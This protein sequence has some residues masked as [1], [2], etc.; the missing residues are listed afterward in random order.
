MV[1]CSAS[2]HLLRTS[3]NPP[4]SADLRGSELRMQPRG[5]SGRTD[6]GLRS[7]PA[8]PPVTTGI[9]L[10]GG[11]SPAGKSATSA[12]VSALEPVA[13]RAR[14]RLH[15]RDLD[16][17]A[18]GPA[19]GARTGTFQVAV[20]REPCCGATRSPRLDAVEPG[21]Q[22]PEEPVLATQRFRGAFGPVAGRTARPSEEP[23]C[24]GGRAV[25][26]PGP[27]GCL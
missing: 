5:A 15:E 26:P 18:S 9:A 17:S 16:V 1:R 25:H 21:I 3:G 23:R 22:E 12:L 11:G 14:A 4:Q 19:G 20:L 10:R 2:R 6:G 7:L 13:N 24:T 27:V 8:M